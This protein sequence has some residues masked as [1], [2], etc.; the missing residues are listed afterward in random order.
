M[1]WKLFRAE[2]FDVV[3]VVTVVEPVLEGDVA[4]DVGLPFEGS[5]ES[6][7]VFL[8]LGD[9]PLFDEDDD[10]AVGIF[11]TGREFDGSNFAWSGE[12]SGLEGR[13]SG[14]LA[15]LETLTTF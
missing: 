13:R 6:G 9:F 10:G 12:L 1:R 11:F 14:E 2:E 3:G 7:V 5:F 4:S 15:A 8:I